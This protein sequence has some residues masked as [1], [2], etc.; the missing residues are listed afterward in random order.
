MWLPS[1]P[2]YWIWFDSPCGLRS[3]QLR[4]SSGW[5]KTKRCPTAASGHSGC[6][7]RPW[8]MLLWSQPLAPQNMCIM[9]IMSLIPSVLLLQFN[10]AS[11]CRRRKYPSK[12]I[13]CICMCMYMCVYVSVYVSVYMCTI[14]ILLFLYKTSSA[15]NGQNVQLLGCFLPYKGVA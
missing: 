2:T 5:N 12:L 6:G 9:A 14:C 1:I 15:E 13:I 11:L 8:D 3:V 4:I 10:V 7:T